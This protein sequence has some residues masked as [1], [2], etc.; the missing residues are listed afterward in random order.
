MKAAGRGGLA[1]LAAKIFFIATG[2]VQQPLLQLAIGQADY[3]ALARVLPVSNVFNSV[4]VSS[5]T[6]G[7]S[8]TVAAASNN[9]RWA[10]RSTLRTHT[11]IPSWRF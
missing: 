2:F 10:L 3:G 5:S 4:I 11:W 8:R 1:V 7:V 6:Q 9:H